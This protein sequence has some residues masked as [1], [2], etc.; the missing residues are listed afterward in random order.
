MCKTVECGCNCVCNQ[1]R[2]LSV[3]E[4]ERCCRDRR[5]CVCVCV[6][7]HSS[8]CVTELPREALLGLGIRSQAGARGLELVSCTVAAGLCLRLMAGGLRLPVFLWA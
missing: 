4:E 1:T 7:A 6:C 5:A 8:S 2:D 3:R